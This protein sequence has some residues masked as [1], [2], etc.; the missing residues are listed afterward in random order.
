[1]S[2]SIIKIYKSGLT[3]SKNALVENIEDFLVTKDFLVFDGVQYIK[4]DLTIQLKLNMPQS[5]EDIMPFDYLSIRND[6]ERIYYYFIRKTRSLSGYTISFDL[7][8]DTINTFQGIPM[9]SKT[10]VERE[11]RDRFESRY[12]DEHD[13][14]HLVRRVDKTL[15]GINPIKYMLAD[16]PFGFGKPNWTMFYQSLEDVNGESTV[17][18]RL[19]CQP[20]EN[21]EMK[22]SDVEIDIDPN[23]SYAII[24][25]KTRYNFSGENKIED[26][27]VFVSATG[28]EMAISPSNFKGQFREYGS[29]YGIMLVYSAQGR[30]GEKGVMPYYYDTNGLYMQYVNI[31]LGFVPVK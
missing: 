26:T 5:I 19:F 6:D 21:I 7:A 30:G 22:V 18:I 12:E 14:T 11:H 8:M 20:S 16:S 29:H 17:G 10:F 15:E 27:I 23:K 1:M 3:P 13:N 2:D 25:G 28:Q 9:T 24:Y 4:H 31:W